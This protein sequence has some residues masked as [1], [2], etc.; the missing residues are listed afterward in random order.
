[1]NTKTYRRAALVIAPMAL[2]ASLTGLSPAT[3]GTQGCPTE[4]YYD[5]TSN[6]GY[7]MWD[8]RTY[9][10]D[11]PGGTITGS[12]TRTGTVTTSVSATGSYSVG[13]IVAQAKIEV[14]GSLTQSVAISVGHT[15]SRNITAG[16]YGNMKYGSWGQRVG[17]RYLVDKSDCKTYTISSGTAYIPTAAVGWRYWE[18][19]S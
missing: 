15:Y 5:I 7:H 6:T 8:G 4:Y 16:R 2:A 14:S 12:V 17:W 9:F 19:T 18:T 3:A 1:M 13:G 10:K 11:G